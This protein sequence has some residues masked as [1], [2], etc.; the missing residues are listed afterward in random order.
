MTPNRL[1]LVD[2]AGAT[3][4]AFMLGVVLVSAQRLVGIPTTTLY[5][6]AAI[7]ILFAVFDLIGYR[8]KSPELFLRGISILNV[9][10]CGLSLSLTVGH[11]DSVTVLG[12]LY[13]VV[14]LS[15][16]LALATTQWQTAR[17]VLE[18]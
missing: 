8:S 4:S 7:P 6:L 18:R 3:L 1:L 14:E 11:R 5:L 2:A 16:V 13:I 15:I 17:K 9:L 12:W 10:Y